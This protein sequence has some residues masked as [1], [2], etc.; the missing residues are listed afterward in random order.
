MCGCAGGG[1]GGGGGGGG[2]GNLSGNLAAPKIPV[3]TGLHALANTGGADPDAG[4]EYTEPIGAGRPLMNVKGLDPEARVTAAGVEDGAQRCALITGNSSRGTIAAP[5]VVANGDALLS[6]RGAGYGAGGFASGGG[7]FVTVDGALGDGVP[8]KTSLYSCN[9]NGIEAAGLDI[10]AGQNTNIKQQIVVE[11][12]SRRIPTTLADVAGV[13]AINA[14]LADI[15]RLTVTEDLTINAPT[16]PQ[17]GR[18]FLLRIYMSGAISAL[19]WNAVYKFPNDV[20]PAFSNFDAWYYLGFIWN[21]DND[22]WDCAGPIVGP[23]GG[24]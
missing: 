13:V 21:E 24:A 8:T 3:A 10:D 11:K 20:E 6:L 2:T 1:F 17:E 16:N 12:T 4:V 15:F 18:S 5:T 23:F 22:T 9:A 14:L 7:L 19:T